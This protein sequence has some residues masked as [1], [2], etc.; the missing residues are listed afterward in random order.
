MKLNSTRTH[1]FLLFLIPGIIGYSFIYP[2]DTGIKK[3]KFT[4][5]ASGMECKQFDEK[6]VLIL[7]PT[8]FTKLWNELAKTDALLSKEI[9]VIDFKKFAVVACYAGDQTNGMEIDSVYI[10]GSKMMVAVS[11]IS[12]GPKCSKAKLLVTPF[13]IIQVPRGKWNSSYLRS[14]VVVRDCE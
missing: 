6:N 3:V 10:A 7:N 13:E 5:L 12:L 14:H 2:Q 4:S 8:D 9:P 11:D 1:F